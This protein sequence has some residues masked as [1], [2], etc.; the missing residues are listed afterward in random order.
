MFKS[1]DALLRFAF[2]MGEKDVI[3]RCALAGSDFQYGDLTSYDKHA[4]SSILLQQIQ[5]QVK[6]INYAYLV[7]TMAEVSD[8]LDSFRVIEDEVICHAGLS[9]ESIQAALAI[10]VRVCRPELRRRFTLEKVADSY[11]I[12]T[13]AVQYNEQKVK[14]LLSDLEQQT[15]DILQRYFEQ[16][17]MVEHD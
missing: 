9:R 1:L 4:Q 7:C 15:L 12:G 13:R 6:P 8:H 2:K 14:K 11:G 16:K 10:V 3:T 5:K 17:G